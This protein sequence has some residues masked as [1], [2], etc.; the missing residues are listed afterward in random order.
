MMDGVRPWSEDNGSAQA[1]WKFCPS[2]TSGAYPTKGGG[3]G[4]GAYPTGEGG[5]YAAQK[6]SVSGYVNGYNPSLPVGP[7]T[8]IGGF[9]SST[10]QLNLSALHGIVGARRGC[11]ARVKA[12]QGSV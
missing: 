8:C 11:V 9:H 1:S 12:W 2:S 5:G 10:F 4:G 7:D 3:G 6:Y